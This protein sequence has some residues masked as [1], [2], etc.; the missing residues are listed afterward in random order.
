MFDLVK[1]STSVEF[2]YNHAV[3]D[4]YGGIAQKIVMTEAKVDDTTNKRGHF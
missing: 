2:S 1:V 3:K 4:L